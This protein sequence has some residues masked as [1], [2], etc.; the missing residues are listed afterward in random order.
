MS[1]NESTNNG[2]D[3]IAQESPDFNTILDE[4]RQKH[5]HMTFQKH[6]RDC[7]V[8]I[9]NNTSFSI[10]NTD[11]LSINTKAL[12][13]CERMNEYFRRRS[14]LL[15]KGHIGKYCVVTSNPLTTRV[16]T[17]ESRA[18]ELMDGHNGE[19]YMNCLGDEDCE[20]FMESTVVSRQAEP[21]DKLQIV[22]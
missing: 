17:I 9:V 6:D 21:V 3:S 15:A 18:L 11:S 16:T 20:V 12:E 19:A 4:L 14:E 13:S 2:T 1:Q 7:I 5:V 10:C 22:E 8:A